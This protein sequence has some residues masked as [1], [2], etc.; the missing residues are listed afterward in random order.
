[1]SY[2]AHYVFRGDAQELVT[3]DAPKLGLPPAEDV[4][5]G[6][7]VRAEGKSG[8]EY[9]MVC[10]SRTFDYT[11]QSPRLYVELSLSDFDTHTLVTDFT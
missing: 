3:K 8:K 1:M 10:S 7:Q 9:K 6:D 11:D 4:H 2:D 5:L